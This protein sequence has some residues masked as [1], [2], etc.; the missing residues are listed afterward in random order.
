M[1]IKP[2]PSSREIRYM[3]RT[4]IKL[5]VIKTYNM[6]DWNM[7]ISASSIRNY[8][9]DDPC[10]DYYKEY[11]IVNTNSKPSKKNKYMKPEYDIHTQYILN[12]GIQFEENEINEIKKKHTVI[13]VGE[14][15]DSKNK[16]K[17]EETKNLMIQGIPI[18]YQ[19]VL[20]NYNNNTYGLPDLLVRSDYINI[21]MGYNVISNDEAMIGSPKLGIPWHYKVID[22]KHSTIPVLYDMSTVSDN[23]NMMPYKG[24]IYIYTMA[25]NQILGLDMQTGFIW[26]KKYESSKQIII[27]HR[28]KLGIVKF[29]NKLYDKVNAACDWLRSMRK[30]GAKWS[31]IPLPSRSELYPNMKN[32]MDS[33]YKN[34]KK[35]FSIMYNEITSIWN[36]SYIMR[37]NAHKMGI[38][39][40]IDI[41][42]NSKTLGMINKT[43][44]IVDKILDINRQ[45][46]DIIRPKY[47]SYDRSNWIQENPTILGSFL[48]YET[49][50][51]N[52]NIYIFMIGIGYEKS[53]VWVYK[54]FIMK[55]LT[56]IEELNMFHK[57]N[58]YINNILIENNMEEIKFYHWSNA[59]K[60]SYDKFRNKHIKHGKNIATY[61]FYDMSKIFL[62]EPIVI[63]NALSYSLK[64]IAKALFKNGLITTIWPTNST[65]SDGLNAM[66][67]AID[68]YNINNIDNDIMKEIINYN[69]IDCKTMWE[70]LVLLRTLKN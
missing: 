22:I 26:G 51:I 35:E 52:N 14:Y 49:I 31:L 11:N 24:Q 68:L 54:N 57:F 38:Y 20:H 41:R 62:E 2:I 34:I 4:L 8:M 10:I 44:T 21:L 37:M 46:K 58:E 53:G 64:S 19:A 7:M 66:M 12:E 1:N 25:L 29:D 56:E 50:N 13:K 9:L 67:M 70:I 27:N 47:I 23:I 3:K 42:C 6:I 32:N 59:E 39:S 69:E 16:D 63:K 17:F 65:C 43:G 18:I 5:N 15:Y 36:C 61:N 28:N 40:Y 55:E 45:N 48:D 30:E 33:P 60:I